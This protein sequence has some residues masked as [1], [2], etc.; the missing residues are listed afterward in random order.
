MPHIYKG[1]KW[2]LFQEPETKEARVTTATPQRA[3]TKTALSWPPEA[4]PFAYSIACIDIV[5]QR[6]QEANAAYYE[7]INA[8]ELPG[9]QALITKAKVQ[10]P[11]TNAWSIKTIKKLLKKGVKSLEKGEDIRDLPWFS[12]VEQYKDNADILNFYKLVCEFVRV[13]FNR[14]EDLAEN[15]PKVLAEKAPFLSMA[16]VF[17]AIAKYCE[18]KLENWNKYR[19]DGID[20]VMT[21]N[22]PTTRSERKNVRPKKR[23]IKERYKQLKW[24]LLKNKLLLKYANLWYRCR[25][26]P[27]KIELYLNELDKEA[28]KI[29]TS[30]FTNNELKKFETEYYPDRSN[31]ETVIA[32]F[33]EATGYPRKWRK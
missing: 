10:A 3:L 13:G 11:D 22:D 29:D 20:K 18:V 25:V 24:V 17:R 7:A 8:L 26:N 16:V 12:S 5:L 31:I 1:V 28:Q 23:D 19:P 4:L 2:P 30:R 14:Q 21:G 33:D 9:C 27:G 15:R 32:P 6:S